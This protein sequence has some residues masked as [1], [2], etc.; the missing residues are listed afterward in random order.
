MRTAIFALTLL[1][2]PAAASDTTRIDRTLT[3]ER[4]SAV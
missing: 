1:A 3:A 4:K 2:A